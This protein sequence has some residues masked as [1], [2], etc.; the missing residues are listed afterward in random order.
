MSKDWIEIG[1]RKGY[2]KIYER[3]RKVYI[4]YPYDKK[5]FRYD[6]LEEKVR[7]N[8]Y[9]E[10]IEEYSYPADRIKLEQ[11]PPV[12][13]GGRPSDIVIYDSDDFAFIVVELKKENAKQE[14]IHTGI[15]ELFGNA[16]LFGVRWALFDCKTEKRVYFS[17]ANFSLTKESDLRKSDIPKKYGQPEKYTYGNAIGLDLEPFDEI[18]KFQ[19][20]IKKC[21]DIIRDNENL[22]PLAAFPVISRIVYTKIYDE[23]NTPEKEYYSF[24]IAEG[25]DSIAVASR[26]ANSYKKA[27]S[28][29]L[30][31]FSP[32]LGIERPETLYQIVENLQ[33]YTFY[34][35][36]YDIKGEAYQVFL[37]KL[38]RGESG[39]YFTPR[40]VVKPT[41][42]ILSPK[43]DEKII[44]PCCGTGGF[45]IYAYKF[46]R[47]RIREQY[48]NERTRVRKEYDVAHY[49]IFG[50]EVDPNVAESCTAG[51]LLEDDAHGHIVITDALSNWDNPVFLKKGVEKDK[52]QVL[53]TNPPFGK[54]NRLESQKARFILGNKFKIPP[55]EVM[56]L[57]RALELLA[58]GGRAGFV[59]PDINL[60]LPDV[61]NFLFENAII[62]GVISL[63]S[64]TFNPYGSQA[65][66]SVI[67]FRKKRREEE[68]TS[69]IFMA[70]VSQIGYDSTGRRKGD[71]KN[72]FEDVV[73]YF[74]KFLNE[75]NIRAETN[76]KFAIFLLK[77]E[78]INKARKNLKVDT[79]LLRHE[80][81]KGTF[82]ALKEV[83][84]V[85]RGYTPGW[86]DYTR[87]GVS[88]LKV[89]NLTNRFIN[90]EFEH[91][92]FVPEEIYEKHQGAK[93]KLYD[94]LLTA[95]AHKSE[96][97]AKKIDILDI[98][99]FNKCMA[100]AELLI[101]RPDPQKIN[102]FYLLSVLRIKEINDQFR[103]CIKGTTAHIY[104]DDIGKKVFVPR[105]S[106]NEEEEIGNALKKALEDFRNFEYQYNKHIN[107]LNRSF[108]K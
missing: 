24:Q 58:P 25:E 50:I 48:K 91:R 52:F 21:H 17:L 15:R 13:E 3:D 46:L 54:K 43:D 14:E 80:K 30:E 19:K 107:I 87:S 20:L 73:H 88:I 36:P 66:T 69:R 95:S 64:E 16:N 10:L 62:L 27:S 90:F 55:F 41:V 60:T 104:P 72:A 86:H 93:V 1:K 59:I 35:S 7:A 53:V 22:S 5:E 68:E 9:V 57:E 81:K 96:Y 38:M 83:A 98:L 28:L 12:R 51:M 6:D 79:Y 26:I 101:I 77:G 74:R 71:G 29:E 34:H 102:P 85:L 99:R 67:F 23:L 39:Q 89:R 8:V 100:V 108:K 32:T 40:E 11:Y 42:S 31:I 106:K 47:D 82:V 2:V 105:L 37:S 75:E 61:L 18:S 94:I 4:K 97:I 78:D 33:K 92:G 84:R 44:D 65:K 103:G 56:V 70:S 76:D 45:L 63:P 49:N